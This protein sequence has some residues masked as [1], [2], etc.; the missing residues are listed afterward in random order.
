MTSLH[1]RTLLHSGAALGA[2]ALLPRAASAQAA[3]EPK[4]GAW[5]TFQVVTRVELAVPQG[6]SQAWIPVPSVNE[7]EWSKPMGSSFTGNA[8]AAIWRDPK[9]GAELVH[10]QW[11]AG[12]AAPVVEVTSRFATRDRSLDL[13]APVNA[14]PLDPALRKLNLAATMLIPTDGIVKET[15]DQI[16]AAMTASGPRRGRSTSGSSTTHFATRRRAAAASATFPP[17]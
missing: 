17:C 4:P 3:F 1:R 13:S 6:K 7:P 12:E 10:A 2:L 16:V 14:P 5:R 9:Y 11:A 8:T 15:S